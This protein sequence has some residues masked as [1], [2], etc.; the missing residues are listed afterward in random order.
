MAFN[1]KDCSKTFASREN[2]NEH[3]LTHLEKQ[4]TCKMPNCGRTFSS[5]SNCHR[6]FRGFHEPEIRQAELAIKN[7]RKQVDQLQNRK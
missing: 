6:H 1:C 5:L 2:L 4:V 3:L 7:F